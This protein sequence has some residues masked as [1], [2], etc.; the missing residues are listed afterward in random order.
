MYFGVLLVI[1]G[2]AVG[3]WGSSIPALSEIVPA[4][5]VTI[6]GIRMT[7]EAA[8][9]GG[10]VILGLVVSA[11]SISSACRVKIHCASCGWNGALTQFHGAGRCPR[12]GSQRFSGRE[13][14]KISSF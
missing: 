12:C 1:A 7:R 9:A 14:G 2:V 10:L 6:A 8:I 3:I 4:A 13:I 5:R 11:M